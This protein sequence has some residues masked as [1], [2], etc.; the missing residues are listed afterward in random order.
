VLALLIE[1]I[2]ERACDMPWHRIRRGLEA[3]QVT[4]LFNLNHRMTGRISKK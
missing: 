3:L 1:R 4:K 2:A